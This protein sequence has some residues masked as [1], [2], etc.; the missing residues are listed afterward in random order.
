MIRVLALGGGCSMWGLVGRPRRGG[1]GLSVKW[2]R[3][4]P[5]GVCWGGSSS[6]RSAGEHAV[7]GSTC[8]GVG[9]GM[10]GVGRG[11]GAGESGRVNVGRRLW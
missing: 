8:R 6:S 1:D 10:Q 4:G 5:V 9:F 7:L 3:G 2:V 11:R